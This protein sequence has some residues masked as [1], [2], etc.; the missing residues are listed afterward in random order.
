MVQ[1]LEYNDEKKDNKHTI[2]IIKRI[3]HK[4]S[5]MPSKEERANCKMRQRIKCNTIE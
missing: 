2:I 4:K 3:V 1:V 5:S